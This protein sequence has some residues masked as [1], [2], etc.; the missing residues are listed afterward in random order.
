MSVYDHIFRHVLSPVR[1]KKRMNSGNA[2]F[3][4]NKDGCVMSGSRRDVHEVWGPVGYYAVY[5]DNYL[6]KFRGNRNVDKNLPQYTA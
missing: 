2:G 3:V 5:C 6:P 4:I 1:L